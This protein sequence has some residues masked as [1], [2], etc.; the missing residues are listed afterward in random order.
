MKAWIV[1]TSAAIGSLID[2]AREVDP[3]PVALVLGAAS[4]ADAVARSG[5]GRVVWA[6][7]SGPV[8]AYRDAV[9]SLV[10]EAG[11]D[12]V[13]VPASDAERALAGGLAVALDAPL[14]TLPIGLKNGLMTHGVHGGIAERAVAVERAVLVADGGG[15]VDSGTSVVVEQVVLASASGLEIVDSQPAP[16][17]SVDLG[18]SRRIVAVGRGVRAA[19]DLAV[20]GDLAARLGADVACSRPI[21]GLGWLPHDRVI[22]LTGRRVAPELYVALGV[23]G[24]L[25]HVVGVRSS[26]VVVA[27][28]TDAASPLFGEVD[29]GVVG[30]LYEIVPALIRALS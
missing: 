19:E 25:Q 22:G 7:T 28:N 13:L 5:V 17:A 30:D 20:I 2:L 12:L 14:L 16:A 10:A 24:Q 18:T 15:L 8:E 4:V 3:E 21:S 6:E 26:G 27:V 1:T 11:A 23:S 29:Y 9:A